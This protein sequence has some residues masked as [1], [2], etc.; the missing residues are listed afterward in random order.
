MENKYKLGSEH[1]IGLVRN[2]LQQGVDRISLY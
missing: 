2:L 1:T